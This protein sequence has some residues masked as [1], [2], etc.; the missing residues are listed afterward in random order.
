MKPSHWLSALLALLGL[1]CAESGGPVIVDASWN[2]SCPSSSFAQCASWAEDTCLGDLGQRTI[3]GVHGEMSCT[4]D[5]MIA[6]CE[7]V[8]RDG[9]TLINLK[10][11]VGDFALELEGAATE[12]TEGA[13]EQTVCVVTVTEDGAEYG[14]KLMLGRCGRDAPSVEQPCQVSNVIAERGIVAFD[15]QCEALLNSAS[16]LGFDVTAVGG[17]PA[18]ISF[19][20]CSGF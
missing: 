17:E 12:A 2:L 4:G 1:S 19:S 15:L 20:N 5:P 10:A 14:R 13:D 9:L 11:S 16:A 7:I 3:A 18:T 8:E 6:T